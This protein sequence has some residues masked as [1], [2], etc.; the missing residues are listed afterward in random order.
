M[1]HPEAR[2][3]T[4]YTEWTFPGRITRMPEFALPRSAPGPIHVTID[5][6]IPANANGVLYSLGAFSGGLTCYV[7]DGTINY[8]YNLF[9]SCAHTSAPQKLPA[10]KTRIEDPDA[11]RGAE[12]RR[13][14]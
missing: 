12:A 13:P 8:E 5:A 4:P 6:E 10:G 1:L 14:L 7:L 9:G 2:V 3:A 11:L